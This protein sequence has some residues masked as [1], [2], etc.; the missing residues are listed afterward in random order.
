MVFALALTR[1]RAAVVLIH[2]IRAIRIADD[3]ARAGA[4]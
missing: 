4:A 3:H 1:R 2:R